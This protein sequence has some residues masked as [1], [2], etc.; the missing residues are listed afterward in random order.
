MGPAEVSWDKVYPE[1]GIIDSIWNRCRNR[2]EA[3]ENR[4]RIGMAGTNDAVE[5]VRG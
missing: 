5:I 3:Y 1:K 2:S 4:F